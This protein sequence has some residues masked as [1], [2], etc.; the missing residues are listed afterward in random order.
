V[1][2]H[3]KGNGSQG[4]AVR[5][6]VRP[7][8]LDIHLTRTDQTSFPAR[9]LRILSAGPLV[10]IE[11]QGEKGEAINVEMAHE[12]FNPLGLHMGDMVYVSPREA[13]VFVEDYTI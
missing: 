13:K 10:K 4:K 7:H 12:R 2:D 3:A 1:L 8:D 6:F 11:L 9:V 5:M